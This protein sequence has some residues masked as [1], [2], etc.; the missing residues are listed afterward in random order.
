PIVMGSY[1]IGPAR[2]VAAA[3]EQGH[4]DAG[5]IWPPS[6][7]PFGAWIVAIGDEAAAIGD[8]L[9]DELAERGLP[10]MVDDRAQSPGA[11]FTDAARIGGPPRIAVGK[12][13]ASEGTVDL[14]V[15]RDGQS[16][17]VPLE[18]AAGRVAELT[19]ELSP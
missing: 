15:R 13:P 4:D 1:G 16:E 3:A 9:A 10:A 12:R 17:T 2:T 6:I 7:A 19:R 8:R 5:L 18:Q 11:K 14:R